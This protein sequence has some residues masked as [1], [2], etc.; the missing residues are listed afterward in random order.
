M[1]M[2]YVHTEDKPV[3]EAAELVAPA[4][5][6]RA[7]GSLRRRWHERAP[8][9][10][11]IARSARGAAGRHSGTDRGGAQARRLDGE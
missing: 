3:R 11:S 5:P 1:F 9:I 8:A 6:S 2:R 10:S 4:Q 7:R